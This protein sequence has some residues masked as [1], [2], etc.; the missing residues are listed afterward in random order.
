MSV[1]TTKAARLELR[2]SVQER[3]RIQSK[4]DSLGMSLSDYVRLAALS[5]PSDGKQVVIPEPAAARITQPNR[6]RCP[7]CD[8]TC[9]S[10]TVRCRNC[11]L[12]VVPS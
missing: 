7:R 6:Y 1:Q 8:F 9:G 11:N 3:E 4:A 10:P 2:L 12:A 5:F